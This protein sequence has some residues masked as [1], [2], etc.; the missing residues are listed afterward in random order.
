MQEHLNDIDK[1]LCFKFMGHL[2][3][4]YP[5]Q[6][7]DF[8]YFIIETPYCRLS[9]C[10]NFLI[11]ASHTTRYI[12]KNVMNIVTC[13]VSYVKSADIATINHLEG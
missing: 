4:L 13:H 2:L 6:V 7:A 8:I 11:K 3:A 5:T 1:D 9:S 12:D 10:F